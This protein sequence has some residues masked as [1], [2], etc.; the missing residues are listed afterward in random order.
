MQFR[1][2]CLCCC[3]SIT[4]FLRHWEWIRCTRQY[5]TKIHSSDN[6]S[7]GLVR[8]G[9]MVVKTLSGRSRHTG[10]CR[11]YFSIL[12]WSCSL[13]STKGEDAILFLHFCL[14]LS[15]H[16]ALSF[17][18]TTRVLVFFFYLFLFKPAAYSKQNRI[19]HLLKTVELQLSTTLWADATNVL[20]LLMLLK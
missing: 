18:H 19:W 16:S 5:L 15:I 10:V 13:S 8:C 14:L 3:G 9:R 20:L 4:V 6:L 11:W 17:T 7:M 12:L 2:L 1:A